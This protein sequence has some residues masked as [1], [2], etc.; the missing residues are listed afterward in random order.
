MLR[1]GKVGL[2]AR[3]EDD[4][5]ILRTELYDDVANA[6]RAEGGPWRPI[7]PGSK[8]PR[9]VVDDTNQGL[10]QFSVVELDGGKLVGTAT[11]W[12]IDTHN[13]SAHIGLGLLP[14]S[15][16]Q[17]YGTDVVA[18]LCHY[19]FVVRGLQRLQ[20]ETLADNAA[21]LRSAERSG[22]VRE[23]VLRSSAW[24]MGE[25]LDEVLLGL[26]AQDWKPDSQA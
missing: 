13:R 9:L 21:M 14:A 25:F 15:R 20:I 17:G 11:L 16:G 24:V 18:V 4:I 23:G 6:A 5:P 26:L 7:T 3:H 2:R 12:G 19:G 8:D 1:G 10:V 22:F